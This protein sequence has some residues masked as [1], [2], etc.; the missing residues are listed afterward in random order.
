MGHDCGVG[1]R[2]AGGGQRGG[3]LWFLAIWVGYQG[4]RGDGFVGG[5]EV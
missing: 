2:V 5:V 3:R 1:C 4:L